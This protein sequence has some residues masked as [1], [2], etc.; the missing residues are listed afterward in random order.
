MEP[1]NIVGL[2]AAV[3]VG[4]EARDTTRRA[5]TEAIRAR[6]AAATNG[7]WYPVD[8]RHQQGGQIRLF[9]DGA[10]GILANVLRSGPNATA[11][12]AM[13]GHAHQD[14]A[15][16]LGEVDRLAAVIDLV[17]RLNR[18]MLT[19]LRDCAA[20][21]SP[22]WAGATTVYPP[23]ARGLVAL[24]DYLLLGTPPATAAVDQKCGDPDDCRCNHGCDIP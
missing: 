5:R 11:D 7:P 2:R 19:R 17:R 22:D 6:R 15:F 8:L 16:L 12:A 13:L 21:T 18:P 9:A 10:P 4:E 24:I 1:P 3:Q 20:D 23:D 14:I